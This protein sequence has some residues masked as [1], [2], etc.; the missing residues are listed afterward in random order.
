MTEEDDLRRILKE[1]LRYLI[2][3]HFPDVTEENNEKLS[4]CGDVPAG[5]Q[6]EHY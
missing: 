5:I 3:G 1:I 4:Q 2:F 6:T